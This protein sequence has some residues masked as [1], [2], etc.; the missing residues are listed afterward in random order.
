MQI[1]LVVCWLLT[2]QEMRM[3]YTL[4]KE[5]LVVNLVGQS[6]VVV[7]WG[8]AGLER[9]LLLVLIKLLVPSIWNGW[10][11]NEF[12]HGIGQVDWLTNAL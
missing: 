7:N 12:T 4:I 5:I 1:I 9:I 6:G 2:S 3:D 10:E 11:Q 8:V